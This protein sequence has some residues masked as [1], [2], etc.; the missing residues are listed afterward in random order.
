MRSNKNIGILGAGLLD[1]TIANNL[2]C[3]FEV[4]EKNEIVGLCRSMVE[5]GWIYELSMQTGLG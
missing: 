4:L 3:N 2:N 5:D 1:L